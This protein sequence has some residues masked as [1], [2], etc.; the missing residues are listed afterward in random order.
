M[1]NIRLQISITHCE[2]VNISGRLF[3]VIDYT[4][5]EN[6]IAVYWSQSGFVVN[7]TITK[8]LAI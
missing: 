5:M 2:G 7:R 3:Y 8:R 4:E 1:Y 6:V